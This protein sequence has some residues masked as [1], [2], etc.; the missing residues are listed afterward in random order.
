MAKSHPAGMHICCVPFAGI[1]LRLCSISLR[2]LRI[3]FAAYLPT[4][5]KSLRDF[6]QS[7]LNNHRDNLYIISLFILSP[8]CAHL[9][10][11][12]FIRLHGV[13]HNL[14]FPTAISLYKIVCTIAILWFFRAFG[15]VSNV[16]IHGCLHRNMPKACPYVMIQT[17]PL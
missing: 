5:I 2:S 6:F 17:V 3:T 9:L 12:S 13:N 8:S 7:L 10:L 4:H 11:R 15:D 1:S 14:Q 16:L